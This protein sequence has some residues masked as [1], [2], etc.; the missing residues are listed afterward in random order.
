MKRLIF[1][2]IF[3]RTPSW[4]Y[5]QTSKLIVEPAVRGEYGRPRKAQQ[6]LTKGVIDFVSCPLMSYINTLDSYNIPSSITWYRVSYGKVLL[7]TDIQCSLTYYYS[8][9]CRVVLLDQINTGT[10]I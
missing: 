7:S 3:N 5:I 4:C 6:Y 2:L 8:R 9:C 10:T 1:V